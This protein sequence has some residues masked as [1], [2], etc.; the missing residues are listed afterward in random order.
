MKKS[1]VARHFSLGRS[2]WSLEGRLRLAARDARSARG[3]SKLPQFVAIPALMLALAAGAAANSPEKDSS[4]A[5]GAR[6]IQS[7]N[8]AYVKAAGG[9]LPL[10]REIGATLA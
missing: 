9:S 8:E 5:A 3:I 2:R 6:E 7:F 1:A 10:G 4:P